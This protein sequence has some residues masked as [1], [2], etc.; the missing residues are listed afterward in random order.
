M[1]IY[2]KKMEVWVWRE[3]RREGAVTPSS[4]SQT[5]DKFWFWVCPSSSLTSLGV[6]FYVF[7]L[8][9]YVFFWFEFGSGETLPSPTHRRH[10]HLIALFVKFSCKGLASLSD[11]LFHGGV[12][13]GLL[14]SCC[15][16]LPHL[17]CCTRW[18]KSSWHGL[19]PSSYDNLLPD[20][21]LDGF[22]VP[23]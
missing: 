10:P 1:D 21:L 11:L 22:V 13:G 23:Q 4:L 8:F 14:S 17:G 16:T 2:T 3:R 20:E 18:F 5:G 7:S 12:L 6:L 9:F 19:A 15:P